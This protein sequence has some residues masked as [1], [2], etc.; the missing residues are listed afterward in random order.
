M[1]QKNCFF[2]FLKE[3]PVNA[4]TVDAVRRRLLS[5][6][7]TELPSDFDALPAN[8]GSYFTT[9]NGSA[10][11]AFRVK[12]SV[13]GYR[14][15]AAHGDSPTFALLPSAL[16]RGDACSRLAVEK[17]GGPVLSS[18][19]DRPLS[20]AGKVC[21]RN[22][23]GFAV[24][25]VDLDRD[26]FIIP[27]VAPHLTR[28]KEEP[29]L[30]PAVHL[31]PLYGGADAPD[32]LTLVASAL[33]VLPEDILDTELFLY[34]RTAPAFLGADGEFLASPRLDDMLSVYAALSA[35]LGAE[36]F[37]ALPIFALFDHEEIGSRTLGGAESPLL[38]NLLY[39]L[40]G[41]LGLSYEGLLQN[42]LFVSADGAHAKHPNYP[43]LSESGAAPVLGGGV[44]IKHN[45]NRR[46]T[47]SAE[48]ASI[49]REVC[50]LAGVPVQD[51][52]N[53]PDVPGGST[54]GALV[55]S[56]L[57]ILALDVGAPQLAM[58]SSYETAAYADLVAMEDAFSALYRATI[59]KNGDGYTVTLPERKNR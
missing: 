4:L 23:E 33:G 7:F 32:P 39:K 24:R 17:Y 51:Y 54:L 19:L 58:H 59:L 1:E 43:E 18:W 44:V 29:T 11:F 15:I 10:L 31:L 38:Q 50:R 20:L 47:T 12:E 2:E 25:T 49:F 28:T 16:R 48:S 41:L 26:L 13:K 34:N 57:P 40:A 52:A 53:R 42:S 55:L 27:S 56:N 21:V 30:N 14:I 35:I 3:A 36:E 45:A 9:V 22:G 37:D 5:A 46:Y 6:G 8:S